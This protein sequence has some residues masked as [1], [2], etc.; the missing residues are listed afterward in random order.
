L[1]RNHHQRPRRCYYQSGNRLLHFL[2][3]HRGRRACGRA[4]FSAKLAVDSGKRQ[5]SQGRVNADA[6][7][8][9]KLKL[10]SV[11]PLE[12][13]C[14]GGQSTEPAPVTRRAGDCAGRE[15]KRRPLYPPKA[16]IRVRHRHVCFGPLPRPSGDGHWRLRQYVMDCGNLVP[17]APNDCHPGPR[18][19]RSSRSPCALGRA[20]LQS[21]RPRHRWG[22]CAGSD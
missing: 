6:I 7:G 4:G 1:R 13:L 3:S 5:N 2:R 9:R 22:P 12:S 14:P 16:D 19:R 20:Q 18:S 17:A 8:Q 10:L 11:A 21:L 15:L